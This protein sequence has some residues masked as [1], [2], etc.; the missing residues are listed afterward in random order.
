MV[1]LPLR[2]CVPTTIRQRLVQ[3]VAAH[4]MSWAM[5]ENSWLLKTDTS[6]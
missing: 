3:I 6:A 4:A 1:I 5:A 2:V